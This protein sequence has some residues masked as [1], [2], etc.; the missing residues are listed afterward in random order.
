VDETSFNYLKKK[1]CLY[2]EL[3]WTENVTGNLTGFDVIPSEFTVPH[4]IVGTGHSIGTTIDCPST[5]LSRFFQF[6]R[7]GYKLTLKFAKTIFHTGRLE[8]IF[9]PGTST[10]AGLDAVKNLGTMRTVFDIRTTDEISFDIPYLLTKPWASLTTK[11]GTITVN[12]I[13]A[14]K[15]P[16][17]V[18]STVNMLWYVEAADDF[19]LSVPYPS[20]AFPPVAIVPYMDSLPEQDLGNQNL[21]KETLVES[22]RSIGEC[23]TNVK[24]LMKRYCVGTSKADYGVPQSIN[25]H[26]FEAVSMNL[27]TGALTYPNSDYGP[28]ARIAAMYAFYKGTMRLGQKAT[29]DGVYTDAPEIYGTM[30]LQY[31]QYSTST[32]AAVGNWLPKNW[33]TPGTYAIAPLQPSVVVKGNIQYA[34]VPYYVPTKFSVVQSSYTDTLPTTLD[35]PNMFA[36]MVLYDNY[37]PSSNVSFWVSKAVGDDFQM[38]F[39]I[40]TPPVIQSYT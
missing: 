28:I 17:T 33:G 7:G 31:H 2:Y 32:G 38:G 6:Y 21:P 19:Q 20:T 29:G 34:R 14:L 26:F 1:R 9:T 8:V 12:V 4:V 13:N 25:P 16:E 22:A 27:A 15:A 24:Q 3:L 10:V 23:F 11:L 35:Q 40:A 30:N 36:N 39:F 37:P 18:S 5:Y